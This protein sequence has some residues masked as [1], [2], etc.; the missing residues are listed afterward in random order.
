LSESCKVVGVRKLGDSISLSYIGLSSGLA[1]TKVFSRH[2]LAALEVVAQDGRFSFDGDPDRFLLYAEAERISSAY[3]FDPLFAVNCSIVDPL[4]HQ[5]EAVYKYLLPQPK[6]R[7]LLADDTGAGKTIMTGLLIK[8]LM[9]RGLAERIL[10][11]TP[12]GL[13]RQWQEDEMGLKFAIPFKL[14]NRAAF[15]SDPTIFSTSERLITSIDFIR[16]DDVFAVLENTSWDLIVVDEAHKLSAFDYGDKRYLSKRYQAMQSLASRCEHFLLLTATP[17]RGRKDTFKN[18]LQLLDADIFSTD[19]LVTSRVREIGMTGANK[20]F[21]RRLKEEMKDW[22]G[23]PLFKARSTKTV[24]YDLTSDEKQLYDRVTD[25]LSRKGEEARKDSN[26]HVSLALMVMQRR[27]TSSIYALLRTL[28]ARHDALLGVLDQVSQNPDIWL[29]KARLDFDVD[30]LDDFDELDDRE[31]TALESIFADPR[32]FR[33]FTTAKSTGE[34]R[35]EADQVGELVALAKSLYEGKAEEQKLRKLREVFREQGVIDAGE[36]LVIFTEHRDTLDYLHKTLVNSGYRV[37]V[38]HGGLGVDE[39]RAA[40][41][42]FAKSAQILI[43]TDAAGEGIN[44]QFCRLL[45]NWDIPWNPNR[46]E[47]RMGRIHRYGQKQDVLVMNMVAQNTRE[48]EVLKKLLEKLDLIRAQMGDD[49]V[50]DVIS[51]IF[52]GVGLDSIIK[53]TFHGVDSAY[54]TRIDEL[55]TDDFAAAIEARRVELATSPIDYH[56]ARILKG[57]SDERRLQPIYVKL[58]FERAIAALGGKMSETRPQVFHIERLPAAIVSRL[59]NVYRTV[60]DAE[61]TLVTF[62]KQFFLEYQNTGALRALHFINPGTPLFDSTLDIV[63][64]SF[65]DD[66][67]KGSILVSPEDRT[68]ALAYL[69]RSRVLDARSRRH[70]ESIADER[71]ELVIEREG[72]EL[73][74]TSPAKL[75]DLKA[76]AVFSKKPEAL[77]FAETDA[78]VSWSFERI[79]KPQYAIAKARAAEDSDRRIGYLEEGFTSLIL[80]LTAEIGELQQKA[81]TGDAKGVEKLIQKQNRIVELKGRRK[82]RLADIER[83]RELSMTEPEVLGCA[84]VVPLSDIEYEGAYGMKRDEEV[85]A[86]AM[87]AAMA[88]ERDAGR[89]PEDMSADNLGYDIRSSDADDIKR[90]IEVKGRSA[91]GGIMMSE[92]EWNRLYQ[93]AES[94]WLYVVL[95]CKNGPELHTIPDP[96]RRLKFELKT[97]GIQYFLDQSQIGDMRC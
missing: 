34:L 77:K 61:G 36:K 46:L 39:R 41:A 81:F 33:L 31:R 62:D 3:Q 29:Q 28:S 7:F 56:E 2:D 95:H 48:G 35:E 45:I 65:K 13:T 71:L 97:K 86:I 27:L 64:A 44:L 9:L 87:E 53:T 5:I 72:V 70:G 73:Y 79:S 74:S 59:K 66:M 30:S 10:I 69:V 14:V 57:R 67:L 58:F 63:K 51:D 82:E 40:M 83:M 21:I 17:H 93:L 55:S 52:N 78:V 32:K 92:N 84:Y 89:R 4:P 42:E 11:V 88:F 25:Y 80:D 23:K 76:P 16:A 8:E 12:G 18:L 91:G 19:D 43:G 50:Y 49:R 75:V 68:A 26:I 1:G 20:F 22:A 15:Q 47:Q 96:A 85:E 38:I 90:Y 24:L 37:V 94:A 6:I 60:I 54:S